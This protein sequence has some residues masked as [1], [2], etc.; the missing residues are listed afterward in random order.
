VRKNLK[1]DLK[2]PGK[3]MWL[4]M[5]FFFPQR[6][7]VNRKTGYTFGEGMGEENLFN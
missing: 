3:K 4:K 6:Y 2:V 7:I 1:G 5:N